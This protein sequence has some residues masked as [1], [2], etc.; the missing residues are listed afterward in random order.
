MKRFSM[1][2]PL[3]AAFGLPLALSLG[4]A[5]TSKDTSSPKDQQA[6]DKVLQ[7]AAFDLSCDAS[8]LEIQKISDDHAM[9]GVKNATYGVRG[10]DRQATYKTS[11]GLG[12]CSI[13]K[14]GAATGS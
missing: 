9:M 8:K 6:R 13:L 2:R 1:T 7:Q 12:N 11:C 5:S 14:D 10:C 4:C 3:A